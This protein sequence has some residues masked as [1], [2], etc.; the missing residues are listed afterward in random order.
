MT[1]EVVDLFWAV[2][3]DFAQSLRAIPDS[4]LPVAADHPFLAIQEGQLVCCR[5]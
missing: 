2:L 3:D 4:W 1:V 5:P